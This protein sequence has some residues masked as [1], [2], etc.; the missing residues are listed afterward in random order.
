MV[1]ARTTRLT[2]LRSD[3]SEGGAR[4]RAQVLT[5]SERGDRRVA[6][7]PLVEHVA[8][9]AD[10]EHRDRTSTQEDARR[11]LDVEAGAELVV[12]REGRWGSS[13]GVAGGDVADERAELEGA[14]DCVE[15]HV[16]DLNDGSGHGQRIEY[17]IRVVN[18][19]L[20]I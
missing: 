1:A 14:D 5:D 15:Q 7:D 18:R 13:R 10:E 9:A 20:R 12:D 17:D 3:S 19:H 2:S 11:D 4:L 16:E 6:E 8:H